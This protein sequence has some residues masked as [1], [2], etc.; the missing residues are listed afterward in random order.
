MLGSH[1]TPKKFFGKTEVKMRSIK[2]II[3]YNIIVFIDLILSLILKSCILFPFLTY[4]VYNKVGLNYYNEPMSLFT[5]L[6]VVLA[7]LNNQ[8]LLAP[9]LP[10]ISSQKKL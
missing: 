5:N 1:Q 4:I 3:L 8:G 9:N 2:T 10:H 6:L 7:V